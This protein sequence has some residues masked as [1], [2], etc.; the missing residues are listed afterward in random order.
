MLKADL[1]NGKHADST[2]NNFLKYDNFLNT[3]KIGILTTP[4]GSSNV[5]PA[6]Y[7]VFQMHFGY[8]W[9]GKYR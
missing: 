7:Q 4:I 6:L 8:H 2:C 1:S 5:Y 9:P 3:D